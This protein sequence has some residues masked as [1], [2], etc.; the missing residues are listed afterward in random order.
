VRA[1]TPLEEA[2]NARRLQLRIN[3]AKS[4]GRPKKMT[5]RLFI[6]I[7]RQIEMGGVETAVCEAEGVQY[8]TMWLH[9]SR[10]PNWKQRLE[11]AREIRKDAWHEMH[12]QNVMM[13]APKNVAASL[14]FLERAFPEKYALRTVQRSITSHELVMDRVSPEQLIEDIKLAREVA[15]ERPQLTDVPDQ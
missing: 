9:C 15:G 13:Q 8:A 3:G 14:W 2:A 11:K 10:K 7:C 1:K 5:A 4:N 6:K 12:V